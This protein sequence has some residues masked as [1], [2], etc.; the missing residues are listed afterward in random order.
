MIVAIRSVPVRSLDRQC[1][2]V[3]KISHH[4]VVICSRHLLVLCAVNCIPLMMVGKVVGNLQE[5]IIHF[6]SSKIKSTWLSS[7]S[8][9]RAGFA[10]LWCFGSH[11]VFGIFS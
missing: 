10:L 7:S 6:L 11:E 4:S 9:V 5:Y 1:G 8:L 2:G 3:Q